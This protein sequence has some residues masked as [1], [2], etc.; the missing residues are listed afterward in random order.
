MRSLSGWMVM[1][2]AGVAFAVACGAR[3]GGDL[4]D[5]E[6]GGY[7][8]VTGG[9]GYGGRG[10]GFF[11][12]YAGRGGGF[13]TGGYGGVDCSQPNCRC[14]SCLATCNCLT[15]GDPFCSYACTGA[16]GYGAIGGFGG[17]GFG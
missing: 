4:G 11:G 10:G 9:N 15:D 7:S 8:G 6:G 12:G 16:G 3:T 2:G 17:K 14:S 1:L 13:F 5:F